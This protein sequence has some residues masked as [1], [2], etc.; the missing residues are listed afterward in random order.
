MKVM[1]DNTMHSC[2]GNLRLKERSGWFA[3]GNSF[4]KTLPLLSDGAFKM[5]AYVCL[6]ADRQTGKYQAVQTELAGA[7]GKSRRIIGKYIQELG[8]KGVCNI[9]MGKN[10][11]ARTRFEVREEYWP[12]QRT[13]EDVSH[14]AYVEAV[15]STFLSLG[16]T[17]GKFNAHDARIADQFQQRHIPLQQIQDALLLGACRKL[18][19]MLNGGSIEPIAS[20][21]YFQGLIAELRDHPIPADYREYLQRKVGQLKKAWTKQSTDEATKRR[22]KDMDCRQAIQ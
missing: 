7:L 6:E 18:I 14:D 4:R 22:C 1:N 3:A 13:S 11:H 5:F 15:R 21:A 8:R 9:R 16:C 17:A 20:L 19:S 2:P 10:Q 12:Y